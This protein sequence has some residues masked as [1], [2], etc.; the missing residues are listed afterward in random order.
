MLAGGGGDGGGRE[1]VVHAAGAVAFGVDGDVEEAQGLDGG[2]DFF[3]EGKRERA[4]EIFAGDFDAGKV[5]VVADA[6]LRETEGVEGGFA[7]LDL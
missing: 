7:L 6:D 1:D 2:G 4:G 5:A 3:K